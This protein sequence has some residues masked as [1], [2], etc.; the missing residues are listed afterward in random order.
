MVFYI[1]IN[2]VYIIMLVNKM[3]VYMKHILSRKSN[4]FKKDVTG[5][6]TSL[7]RSNCGG[8]DCTLMCGVACKTDCEYGCK[9][10]CKSTCGES[11]G[12]GSRWD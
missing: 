5:F 7:F 4:K 8:G 9:I 11:C 3:E 6:S 1:I 2:F 12:S 10:G